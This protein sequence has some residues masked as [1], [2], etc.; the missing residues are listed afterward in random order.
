MRCL[1]VWQV[2]ESRRQQEWA[3]ITGTIRQYLETHMS[4][5]RANFREEIVKHSKEI[6]ESLASKI[7]GQL[8][9]MRKE[10]HEMRP[11][12]SPTISTAP[13]RARRMSTTPGKPPKMAD[14]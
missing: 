2:G 3:G 5:L 4:V 1:C 9:E 8:H 12:I 13:R 14:I 11:Q 10:M 7:M 6:S